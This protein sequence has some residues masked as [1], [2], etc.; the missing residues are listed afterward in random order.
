MR[1]RVL[2]VLALVPMLS[3]PA[4]A[5]FD[6]HFHD[7]TLRLD[8]FHTGQDGQE[9]FSVDQIVSDGPW[10]GSKTRMLDDLNLGQDFFEVFDTETN[11]PLYSRG[12]S[13]I[14]GEWET[15]GEAARGVARTY[16]ESLRMPW[17]RKAVK[18]VVSKRDAA[19]HF[20]PV[21]S[22]VIDPSS[23]FAN[24]ASP[25]PRGEVW[26]LLDSGPPSEKV[27]LLIVGEGFTDGERDELRAAGENMV[28]VLFSEE[29]FKSRQQDFNIRVLFVPATESGVNRP[30]A[31]QF[32]RSPLGTTYNIFDSERYALNLDNRALRDA[33]SGIPYEF[34]EILLNEEQYGGGGIFNA[35]ATAS[36]RAG[37][38]DYLLI[39][40]FGHH[41]AGLADEYYTSDVSYSTGRNNL[42]EPWEPN[43]TALHDQENLKWGDLV[44]EGTPLPTPWNKEHY[45]ET[46][47]AYQ[48]RRRELRRQKVEEGVMDDFFREVRDW[49]TPYLADHDHAGQVGAFEG[50]GYEAHG[51]YR[52]ELDCLMFTRDEVGFCRVCQ[53][54][55]ERVIDL[56]SK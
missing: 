21:W 30:R 31:G 1:T 41:F 19:N 45:E 55:I 39:H 22:T 34:V 53:R 24:P 18:I 12:Y 9:I 6:S 42:P 8:Y 10:A 44:E 32:R 35:H 20:R 52:S 14:F 4:Y 13:S 16:H 54:A 3:A 2:L 17:P 48:D 15:T 29:P 36:V 47:R 56:Y 28:R 23:R 27:D 37:F 11:L 7:R 26:T 46:S 25:T 38:V 49:T 43:A 40:E 5:D 33:A 51:L 50:A